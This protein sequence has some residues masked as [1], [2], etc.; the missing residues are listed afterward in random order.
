MLEGV[1]KKSNFYDVTVIILVSLAI[2]GFWRGA[3]N[4]MDRYIFPNEFLLSQILTII[5]GIILLI[6]ISKSKQ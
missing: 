3:W 1:V 6:I 5:G 4:L 2:I